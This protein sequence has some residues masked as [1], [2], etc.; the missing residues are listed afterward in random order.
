M[1]A[2]GIAAE[3]GSA[4]CIA[5]GTTPAHCWLPR[6]CSPLPATVRLRG[7]PGKC[8][9]I[10]ST[11]PL[12]LVS[13][14]EAPHD[15][16]SKRRLVERIIVA[17]SSFTQLGPFHNTI[18]VSQNTSETGSLAWGEKANIIW[19]PSSSMARL[20]W[21][22]IPGKAE[23]GVCLQDPVPVGVQGEGNAGRCK[24]RW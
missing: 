18:F 8:S 3:P 12:E 15:N 13:E 21:V 19:I 11:L 20:K 16:R 17:D 10:R 24:R 7:G 4:G 14:V 22:G 9:A 6:Y 23:P 1:Q 5:A 2:Q